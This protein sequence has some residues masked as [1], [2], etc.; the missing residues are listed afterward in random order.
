MLN[1]IG[2]S[3]AA[4]RLQSSIEWVYAEGKHV[5]PD[6]GGMASTTEFTD[7]VIR[8]IEKGA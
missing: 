4:R 8:Q 3:A 2:E 1:H 5:T 7:A 6:V